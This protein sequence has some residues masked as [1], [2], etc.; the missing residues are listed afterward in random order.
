MSKSQPSPRPTGPLW[1]SF[2][3]SLQGHH[4]PMQAASSIWCLTKVLVSAAL[5]HHAAGPPLGGGEGPGYTAVDDNKGCFFLRSRLR[6]PRSKAM[7]G[8]VPSWSCEESLQNYECIPR[9]QRTDH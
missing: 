4:P 9:V 5:F 8:S 1:C 2:L 7:R 3:P 6:W